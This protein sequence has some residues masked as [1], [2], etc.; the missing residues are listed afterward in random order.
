MKVT[1]ELSDFSH[2]MRK[3][4]QIVESCGEMRGEEEEQE[5]KVT[6]PKMLSEKFQRKDNGTMMV[7]EIGLVGGN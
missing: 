5:V 2:I 1:D 3:E 6:F 4:S 7:M